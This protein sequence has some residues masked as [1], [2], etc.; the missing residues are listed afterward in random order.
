MRL[1]I[2]GLLVYF[3]YDYIYPEQYSYMVALKG[4]LD[5]KGHCVLEMPSGTGKTVSLL[6]LIVAYMRAHPDSIHKLVYCSRTVPEMQKVMEEMKILV[7]YYTKEDGVQP[8]FLGLI[9]SAR[10]NLCIHPELKGE[11]DGKLVDAKCHSMTT[12]FMRQKHEV[13]P[14]VPLCSLYE[15]FDSH[16]RDLPLPDGVYNLDDLREYGNSKGFC[17]YYLSRYAVTYANVV[18]YSYHYLLDPK[19]AEIVSR[20]LPKQTCVVFDEAHNIDNVCIDSMSVNISRRTLD[21]SHANLE[22]LGKT[23]SVIKETNTRQLQEEYI[24]LVEGLRE[25]NV[26]RDSDVQL[27]NPVLPDQVL[28]EAIPGS[29]RRADH[30]IA[31]MKRFVEYLKTRLRV[32]HVV[33]EN[34]AAFL[35][36]LFQTVCIDR[37]PLRFCS[38]RLR[39]LLHTL[40]LV[41]IGDYSSLTVVANFATLVSTYTKG[42]SLII[43]PFDDRSPSI[44]NPILH[45]SCMDASLAITPVFKRF[46]SV[47]ITSGAKMADD[48]QGS[49][50][51]DS[52]AVKK[53]KS[54][55][56]V[57]LSLS[58]SFNGLDDN[59]NSENVDVIFVDNSKE[60]PAHRMVLSLC[61]PYFFKM[62]QGSGDW[63]EKNQKNIPIPGKFSF[64]IFKTVVDL[65]YG[66]EVEVPEESLLELYRAA[67]YLQLEKLKKEIVEGFVSWE[68]ADYSIVFTLCSQENQS[69][70]PCVTFIASHLAEIVD[71]EFPAVSFSDIGKLSFDTVLNIAKSEDVTESEETLHLFLSI[72][73]NQHSL[74]FGMVM[75]LF[76]HIR[77]GTISKTVLTQRIA[78]SPYYNTTLMGR[79]LSHFAGFKKQ[80]VYSHPLQYTLRERQAFP[81][82][83]AFKSPV[84]ASF[85]YQGI[86]QV[87]V[88]LK[89]NSEGME[90]IRP[91]F[92]ICSI[93]NPEQK[94]VITDLLP[95]PQK[96]AGMTI[97]VHPKGY[98]LL[99]M[100]DACPSTRTLTHSFKETFPWLVK[101]IGSYS[102]A[103]HRVESTLS[104]ID[105]YPRILNFVP[106]V[107]ISF[108]M[109]LARACVCPMIVA[110]GNDQVTMSSKFEAREDAAVIRNYGNLLLEFSR[111]VPDGIACFFPSYHYME[112]VVTLW[113]DQGIMSQVQKN[114]L[115]FIETQ[116]FVE[117]TVALEN[118]IK[119]CENGRGAVL[120]S[121]ARGKVSE[122]VDFDHHLGRA[123]IMF[124]I[125][126]VYTQSRIL[127][128]RLEYLRD[129]FQIRE[130]DFLTFDA[131]RHAAQCVGRVLRGKTDYGLMIFADKRFARS[132][133]RSKLPKWIMEYLQDAVCNLSTEEAVQISKTFLRKMA[134]PFKHE[135]Q[136]GVSLLTVEQVQV[137]QRKRGAD[138]L[139]H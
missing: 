137:N 61:S 125:P 79:A 88:T 34:P 84:F 22:V 40:E 95:G 109:T 86:D 47:V 85:L 72:W 108:S 62:F 65:L 122:G 21:R 37:K 44:S 57:L 102:M 98:M 32:Q 101:V 71:V 127:K 1:N 67:D 87:S 136:L 53:P 68:V 24:R 31:F 14:S 12:S 58:N 90:G 33:S 119:A 81:D 42:F 35:H 69:I 89:R 131:M 70:A 134:Q 113:V 55:S 111:I 3:P 116:D 48:S 105:M 17:P 82:V 96:L 45:F 15:R 6:S 13:D 132:D 49:A 138:A 133:K 74:S 78:C 120:L 2:D 118:Y 7:E 94:H 5:A 36:H 20:D 92:G 114:K 73:A 129:N 11:R 91:V 77:Y 124:G 41:N 126:Y 50:S 8:K 59:F 97:V 100:E 56:K 123:V 107:S 103:V 54:V 80:H 19:I 83:M 139:L 130:N 27:A 28:Q 52:P 16:G 43:E 26:A 60:V 110:K 64:N 121:V 30:F 51:D 76:S 18:V 25:A 106:A 128:A 135:D 23:L 99:C 66:L 4:T 29:I 117:T 93:N 75:E 10:K 115:V 63:Q 104:P 39:S 46:Q 112:S 38:E 9:L